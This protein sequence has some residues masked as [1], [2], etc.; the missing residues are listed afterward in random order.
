MLLLGVRRFLN[1]WHEF[2]SGNPPVHVGS[3]CWPIPVQELPYPDSLDKYKLFAQFLL[4]G[5][6]QCNVWWLDTIGDVWDPG[7]SPV[8]LGIFNDLCT[9]KVMWSCWTQFRSARRKHFC[10]CVFVWHYVWIAHSLRVGYLARHPMR[11]RGLSDFYLCACV[12]TSGTT[13]NLPWALFTVEYM[14]IYSTALNQWS[15][16]M[17]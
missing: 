9:T 5:K 10:Y 6:V 14:C 13:S 4:Q 12:E 2:Y 7:P 17:L 11:R 16:M 3:H 15:T 8:R 1:F